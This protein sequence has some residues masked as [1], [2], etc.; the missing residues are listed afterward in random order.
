VHSSLQFNAV[1]ANMPEEK[2]PVGARV[3]V[4]DL[5]Q[6]DLGLGTYNG[7][8]AF[9]QDENEIPVPSN[10]GPF[11]SNPKIT[12]D[13]GRVIYGFQCWWV[14]TNDKLEAALAEKE[15]GKTIN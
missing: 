6:N 12:L 3:R 9:D 13:S 7:D 8:V 10:P 11:D 15:I 14:P 4:M 1:E 5:E 2:T